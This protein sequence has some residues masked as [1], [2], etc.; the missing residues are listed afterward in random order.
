[1]AKRA[2]LVDANK[3]ASHM[4]SAPASSCAFTL[5]SLPMLSPS[6]HSLCFINL[7]ANQNLANPGTIVLM[8]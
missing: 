6:A 3:R 8:S 4:V 1:M 2:R 5:H 7:I